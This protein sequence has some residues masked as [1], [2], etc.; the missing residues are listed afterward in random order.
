MDN[1]IDKIVLLVGV[2]QLGSRHLQ[3]LLKSNYNLQIYVLDPNPSSLELA[4]DRSN[5]IN[6]NQKIFFSDS[7]NLIPRFYD[8]A[9]I[10]T[11]SNVREAIVL[12]IINEFSVKNLILEKILFPTVEAYTNVNNALKEKK[13][14]IWVNHPRRMINLYKQIRNIVSENKDVINFSVIG[15]NWGLACN[16]LHFIDLFQY[17]SSSKVTEIFSDSIDNELIESKRKGY[18]EFSGSIFGKSENNS[19][20][21]ITASNENVSPIIITINSNSNQWII[22]ESNNPFYIKY[23]QDKDKITKEK[24]DFPFQSNLTTT[25]ANSILSNDNLELPTYLE[26]E[27]NHQLFISIFLK[28]YIEISKID[29]KTCPI[30]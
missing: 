20:F 14:N 15:G 22:K 29:T 17:L 24:F 3:G 18:F 7:W 26:A 5:E 13:I 28:K 23:N 6:H 19:F 2:G 30:T 9:I 1:N 27:K 8:L 11:N 12:K 21:S 25:I 4:K 10:A 16:G